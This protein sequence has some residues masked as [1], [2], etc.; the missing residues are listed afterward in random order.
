MVLVSTLLFAIASYLTPLLFVAAV[1]SFEGVTN[2]SSIG[3]L[4][5]GMSL[6]EG[7]GPSRTRNSEQIS[8]YMSIAATRGEL[9]CY[10]Y[11]DI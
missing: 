6:L 9:H 8:F 2:W 5:P 1:P 3:T 10:A 4:V 7:L 11:L